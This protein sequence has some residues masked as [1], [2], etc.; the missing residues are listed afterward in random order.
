M[1]FKDRLFL[2]GTQ[3]VA[4]LCF[5][6]F[7]SFFTSEAAGAPFPYFGKEEGKILAGRVQKGTFESLNLLQFG[8]EFIEDADGRQQKL[9]LFSWERD[10]FLDAPADSFLNIIL[11]SGEARLTWEFP[12]VVN[13]YV[14]LIGEHSFFYRSAGTG[15]PFK[16][17]R[18]TGLG[19]GTGIMKRM[20]EM[21]F[22]IGIEW[23]PG[24]LRGGGQRDNGER[25]I[26]FAQFEIDRLEKSN[27]D[28][29]VK[30]TRLFVSLSSQ[31]VD[32]F[33]SESEQRDNLVQGIAERY[34]PF[35]KTTTL[36]LIARA[37]QETHS[38]TYWGTTFG[39][40]QEDGFNLPLPGYFYQ[41]LSVK[42]YVNGEL[43]LRSWIT[44]TLLGHIGYYAAGGWDSHLYH[45]SSIGVTYLILGKL[46]LFAEG[47][48]GHSPAGGAEFL[49]GTAVQW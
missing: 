14:V 2:K 31:T 30:G 10:F 38:G 36:G 37:G 3:S 13:P 47:A 15:D 42:G 40:F 39:S 8:G 6:G 43:H 12:E 23:I 48:I 1:R 18:F 28:E 34:F 7:A 45:S 16:I 29:P 25:T 27:F 21:N 22:R 44:P 20:E 19:V 17:T 49:L 32:G 41:Q 24:R 46:P 35:F 4:L 33:F 11:N 5:L 26:E 9:F